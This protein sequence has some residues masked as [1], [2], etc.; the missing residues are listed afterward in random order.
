MAFSL[1][2]V[3]LE[4]VYLL[5]DGTTEVAA[6]PYTDANGYPVKRGAVAGKNVSLARIQL[7]VSATEP[8]GAGNS[9]SRAFT[10]QVELASNPSFRIDRVVPCKP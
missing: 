2:G 10:G 7:T 1:D 9:V 4:Y 8:S 6:A 3:E 5:D